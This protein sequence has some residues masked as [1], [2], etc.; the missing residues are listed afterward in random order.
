MIDKKYSVKSETETKLHKAIIHKSKLIDNSV[1]TKLQELY[2]S[3]LVLPG[4][5][6]VPDTFRLSRYNSLYLWLANTKQAILGGRASVTAKLL[7]L[8]C[9]GSYPTCSV[10]GKVSLVLKDRPGLSEV[11]CSKSCRYASLTEDREASLTRQ[12]GV[13]NFFATQKFSNNREQYLMDKYGSNVKGPTHVP[14]ALEKIRET[15]LHRYGVSHFAK[16]KCVRDK[17]SKTRQKTYGK[18][19]TSAT[20][21]PEIRARMAATQKA[22]SGYNH[23]SQDPK[24]KASKIAK[25]LSRYGT[26]HPMQSQEVQ[27]TIA[28]RCMEKH[29]VRHP[30]QTVEWQEKHNQYGYKYTDWRGVTKKCQGYE[31]Q[32][33]DHMAKFQSVQKVTTDKKYIQA[34]TY[35][36][37]ES[38]KT[39]KYFP[40]IAVKLKSGKILIVEVKSTWTLFSARE[41][42]WGTNLSKFKAA[43]KYYSS[44]DREFV[45]CIWHNK[46]CFIVREPHKGLLAKLNKLGIKK[47]VPSRLP[48]TSL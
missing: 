24:V 34:V 17:T 30:A 14:G 37:P 19:Y 21:V 3:A 15:S 18:E 1:L 40:D 25:S 41:S 10:C 20:Q 31:I 6:S 8:L 43:Y 7:Y 35:L 46:E 32:V 2:N 39:H 47:P 5:G 38:G 4:K 45:L 11:Y 33:L 26:R 22:N 13:P 42:T 29:G 23:Q 9:F 44:I 36:K 27:D 28:E 48:L 16:A 12:F